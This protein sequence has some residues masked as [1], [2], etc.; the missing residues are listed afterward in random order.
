MTQ[1]SFQVAANPELTG[2]DAISTATLDKSNSRVREMFRQIAPRYDLMNHLLSLNIDRYWRR[3]AVKRLRIIPGKPI[4]DTCTGTGDL[5]IAISK[6]AGSQC[7]VVGSD[8]CY[9]MLEIARDKRKPSDATKGIDFLEADSQSLPFDTDTFGCVTVAFGLRNVA[10]TDQG[11]SEMTRVCCGGGQVM[12]LEFSRPTLPGLRGLYGFYFT[13]ILPRVGQWFARNN[14]DAY[15]YLPE[16]VGQFPD[17][18][19][20]ADRMTAAG[21]TDVNYTPLTFGVATIYEGTKPLKVKDK[22]DA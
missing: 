2:T 18:Q 8:F 5:A 20:L 17:G 3:S 11:L 21:L 4:L 6:K 19:A 12:V 1:R 7:E 13:H 10:D 14:K 22:T 9:A 15:S 16:S